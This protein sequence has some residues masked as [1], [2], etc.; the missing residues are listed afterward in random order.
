MK[1][2]GAG[3]IGRPRLDVTSVVG[4]LPV[5]SRA[6]PPLAE[7]GPGDTVNWKPAIADVHGYALGLGYTLAM[8]CAL[9]V[10]AE[11]TEFQIRE[12]Q[13]GLGS[14]QHWVATWFWTGSGFANEVALTGRMFGAAEALQHL[15]VNRVVPQ[16]ELLSTAE[17]A[18]SNGN[19][20]SRGSRR[21]DLDPERAS[22]HRLRGVVGHEAGDLE[23]LHRGEVEPIERSTMNPAR[24][25]LLATCGLHQA[26]GKCSERE[27]LGR[28][29]LGK[30]DDEPTP[31]GRSVSSREP[32]RLELNLRLEL[33]ERRDDDQ[34]FRRHAAADGRALRLRPEELQ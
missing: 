9:V 27:G 33:G 34:V 12:V 5:F 10:A 32:R 6:G 26:G 14:G 7:N 17:A 19:R 23:L 25:G 4:S 3:P 2:L 30:L 15:M 18:E 20:S 29:K 24:R 21:D 11:G 1:P 8:S 31:G 28:A 13:R 16:A 22:G